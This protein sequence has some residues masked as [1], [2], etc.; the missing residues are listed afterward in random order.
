MQ[1]CLESN[2]PPPTPDTGQRTTPKPG[3]FGSLSTTRQQYADASNPTPHQDN[4]LAFRSLTTLK[5]S[6]TPDQTSKS[7][8]NGCLATLR[9]LETTKQT[10]VQRGQRSSHNAQDCHSHHSHSSNAKSSRLD[11][12]TGN[13]SGRPAAVDPPTLPTPGNSHCGAPHGSQQSSSTPNKQPPPPYTNYDWDM[14]ISSPISHDYPTTTQ[15]NAIVRS[16][17][18]QPSTFYLAAQPTG[19]KGKELESRETKH[20]RTCCSHRREQ[21]Q[22]SS[23]FSRQE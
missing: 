16:Q 13:R 14:D 5:P 7:T 15:P 9:S 10:T 17:S 19:R 22:P 1:N 8:S 11:R 6:S 23:S 3:P 12:R 20:C 2:K 21:T 4:T 18:R